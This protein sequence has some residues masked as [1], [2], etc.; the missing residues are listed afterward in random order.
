[1]ITSPANPRLKLVRSLRSRP[2]REK[3][4]LFACEGEDLVEAALDA[5]LEPAEALVDAERPALA[6]RLPRAERV[7]PGLMAEL[8]TLAHPPRVV[9]VFRRADLRDGFQAPIG[10]ALW[11]VAD[12][13]NVGTLIRA[14]GALGPAFVALSPGCADPTG[15]KALRASMG[16]IFRVPLASFDD[17][18]TPRVALVPAGGRPLWDLELGEHAT[19]VVGAEREGLP[20]DV[21][22][23][24]DETATIPLAAGADS[25]NVALAGAIALYDCRRRR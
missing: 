4:G 18:P 14:A 25:L 17:V 6:E 15:P 13:G 10:L 24:C 2:R 23:D 12:P 11:R 1:V 8:S 20:P 21:I 22:A 7:A 3:L 5:G 19:F 9:A 16:A